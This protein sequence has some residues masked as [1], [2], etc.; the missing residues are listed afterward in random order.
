VGIN[1]AYQIP[2]VEYCLKKVGIK[3]IVCAES[4][5]TQN[6]YQMLSHILPEMNKSA[7]NIKSEQFPNISM[8][9]VDS[10]DKLQ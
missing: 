3:A 6:Y 1:P 8:V 9:I 7:T 2:E 10:K 4:Y 5:K